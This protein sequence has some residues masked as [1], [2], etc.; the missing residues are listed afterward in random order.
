MTTK[1]Q[2]DPVAGRTPART[3]RGAARRASAAD[4]LDDLPAIRESAG[5]LGPRA[6]RTIARIQEAT[7]QVFLLRGYTGTTIDEIT[8]LA[9][10][11]RASFYTY[12]PSKREVLLSVGALSARLGES[13]VA[14]LRK[15]DPSLASLQEWVVD[16]FEFMD[17]HGSFAFAWTQAAQEDDSI[18][19]A[20]MRTHLLMCRHFGEE[21]AGVVG[22]KVDDPTALGLT[23]FS[24][25][26]RSW[27]YSSLYRD[28]VD[29]AVVIAQSAR[30][31]WGMVRPVPSSVRAYH[32]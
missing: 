8:G 20:G 12:F 24:V 30:A 13:K 28:E 26:E 21:L 1:R 29:R 25:L 3:R 7:R 32:R 23:A 2:P 31:L 5:T 22:E 10:V 16:Y 11:S 19:R 18:R 15:V 6:N 14:E 9:G 4:A 27:D 17:T